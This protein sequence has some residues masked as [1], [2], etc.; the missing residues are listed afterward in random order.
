MGFKRVSRHIS[1]ALAILC[2]VWTQN[3]YAQASF[4]SNGTGGRW[5]N[6]SSWSFIGTDADGVPDSDDDV[7]ILSGDVIE[8]RN[9]EACDD[10]TV[11]GTLDYGRSRTLTVSG[12]LIMS[13]TSAIIEGGNNRVMDVQGTFTV[14]SGATASIV[15][16][17]FQV[18]G[19]STITG[20]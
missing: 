17:D 14:A 16:D 15:I 13:G 3:L 7:T 19:L 18:T 8:I 4:Q 1:Y 2:I 6:S 5:N 20:T 12:N 10:I 11:I 9:N